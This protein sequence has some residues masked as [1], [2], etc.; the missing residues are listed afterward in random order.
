MAAS[1]KIIFKIFIFFIALPVSCLAQFTITGRILNQADKKPVA[2]ASVFLANGTIGSRTAEAGTFLLQNIKPG[3]YQL[4]VSIVGFVAYSQTIQVAKS[5]MVLPDIE[6]SPKTIALQEVSVKFDPNREKNLQLFKDEFLGKSDIAKECKLLNP[7]ILDIS[8]D[9]A[10][11]TLTASSDDF[12]VIENDALGY[13]VNYL[14]TNF[15]LNNKDPNAEEIHYEGSILFEE[16]KG[17]PEQKHGW[18]KNREEVYQNSAVHFFRSALKNRL[19]EEGFSVHQIAIYNNP[20]R[21]PDSLI[22]A[23]ISFFKNSK[24]DSLSYWT[25]KSK[26]PKNLQ[27]LMRYPL[28]GK[29]IIKPSGMPG[30][31]ALG[32]E[33]DALY[34]AYNKNHHFHIENSFNHLDASNTEATVVHFVTPY[35]FIEENGGITNPNSVSFDGVWARNRIAEELPVNYEPPQSTDDLADSTILKKVTASLKSFEKNHITE[36]AYLHFDKPFYA[37]GDTMYFKA[38][39]TQGDRSQLSKLS[40]VLHVDL[41]GGNNKVDQSIQLPLTDGVGWGEFVLPDTLL[42]GNYQVNAY[43]QLMRNNEEAGFFDQII[44]IEAVKNVRVP[45]SNIKP[46]QNESSKADIQFSP[47]GGNLV[48]GIRSKVAFKAIGSNGLGINVKG[49]IVDNEDREV[50]TF[51]ATHLGMGYFYIQP[52]A[53]KAYKARLTYGDGAQNIIDLPKADE[54]GIVLSVNNDQSRASITIAANKA[55]YLENKNKD[56]TLLVYSGGEVNSFICKLNIPSVE[57]AIEK[58]ELHSGIARV[59]LFSPTGEPLSERL[60]FVKNTNLLKL[61]LSSDKTIYSKRGKVNITLNASDNNGRPVGGHFSV[62]V[63]DESQVP[64]D[65]NA[66]STILTSLLLASDLKGYVEQPNY[67]FNSNIDEAFNNLDV[68]L[69]TQGYRRF[70]WKQV[71]DD[72]KNH[73]A[74]YKPEESLELSG[75]LKTVGGK[76]VPNGKVTMMVT[77]DNLLRDTI[78]DANGNFRFTGLYLTDTPIMVLR[79]KSANEGNNVKIE[80]KHPDKPALANLN[81]AG[82]G[83]MEIPADATPLMQRKYNDEQAQS[84][85]GITLKQVNI[86]INKPR[87]RPVIASSANL[88]GPGNADFILMGDQLENCVGISCLFGKIPGAILYNGIFY[89]IQAGRKELGG[90]PPPQMVIIIDGI[91]FKQ[92]QDPFAMIN[93]ND[94]YSIEVLTSISNLTIYGS[95]A[96][97]GALIVTTK[98]GGEKSNLPVIP[99]GLISFAYNGFYRSREFYSPKYDHPASGTIR[100]DLRSTIYWKPELLTDKDGNA[101]FEYFNADGPGTY[102]VVVEG[103]DNSGNI[104]RQ[105]LRY[106]VE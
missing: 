73:E 46:Q 66:E 64:V 52:L 68:L 96:A 29:E 48:I 44:P 105:L 42:K 23:K 33:N 30:E 102:R 104:G 15:L 72:K 100:K 103:I 41:T 34:I 40:G 50:S 32:C 80:I 62:S 54:K 82:V 67:Y 87:A 47:E 81:A 14:L 27:T 43:T 60:I 12:L 56:Y 70:E 86:K 21:P 17:T 95:Q 59:T 106:K 63:I 38:Y 36:K 91:V 77:K 58:S 79:A 78:A 97:G 6:I 92:D 20:Q 94:I 53:G 98:R 19:D 90:G 37:A 55:C 39:V 16:M 11:G 71:L 88:N 25:K 101:S 18:E 1:K 49:V 83:I 31:Y 9:D 45:E 28:T 2:N 61:G 24:R 85:N 26:L 3:K 65:E 69:L 74:V 84:R 8:Y 51:A 10:T 5:N 22:K 13:K 99:T 7:E 4:V 93:M 35:A 57:V 89:R 76:P 75:I